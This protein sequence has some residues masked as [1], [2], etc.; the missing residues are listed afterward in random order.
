MSNVIISDAN[1]TDVD[2]LIYSSDY[3]PYCVAAKRYLKGHNLTFLEIDL[4]LEP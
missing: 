4:S 3:C 2:F 1:S